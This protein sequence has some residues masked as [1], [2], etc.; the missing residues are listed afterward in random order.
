MGGRSEP[1][2]HREHGEC[3]IISVFF[4]AGTDSLTRHHAWVDRFVGDQA[5]GYFVPGFAGQDHAREAI[6]AAKELI[7]DTGHGN[8]G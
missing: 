3:S 1:P 4:A 5:V 6:L 7:R 2:R 8:A